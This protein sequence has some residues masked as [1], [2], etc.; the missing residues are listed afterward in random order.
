M[1]LCGRLAQ[2]CPVVR[3]HFESS[4]W[5]IIYVYKT[6]RGLLSVLTFGFF[7][8]TERLEIN[9]VSVANKFDQLQLV[10]NSGIE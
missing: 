4:P 6:Q 9:V 3:F 8:G 5:F 10:I 2:L 1:F 7:P